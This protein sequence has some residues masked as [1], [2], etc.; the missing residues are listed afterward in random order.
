MIIDEHNNRV[1]FDLDEVLFPFIERFS[2]LCHHEP[3][4]DLWN[5]YADWGWDHERFIDKY[6]ELILNESLFSEGAIAPFALKTLELLKSQ[7]YEIIVCTVRGI[8]HSKDVE[9][10]AR[11]QTLYWLKENG[12]PYDEAIFTRDKT[13][14]RTFCFFD[15]HIAHYRNLAE[16][17]TCIPWLFDTKYNER[18]RFAR[19]V[20]S[21]KSV[22]GA[23]LWSQRH[24]GDNRPERRWN[25]F[26][27]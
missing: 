24:Q 17:S 2:T 9:L 20:K 19:R 15:D 18:F 22:Y 13:D 25:E 8:D 11:E 12:V 26:L 3:S 21:F 16:N 14:S 4:Y 10:A 23:V 6:N 27:V 5:F 7:G 1:G